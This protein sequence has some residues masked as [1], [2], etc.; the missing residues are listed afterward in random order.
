MLLPRAL[1]KLAVYSFLG[2]SMTGCMESSLLQTRHIKPTH[3]KNRISL[4]PLACA[5]AHNDYRHKTPLF[6]AL[7]N[8]FSSI[9][10]DVFLVDGELLVGHTL[11]GTSPD[12]TLEDLYLKPLKNLVDENN[13]SVYPGTAQNLLLMIDVKSDGKETY[14]ALHETLEKY[15]TM[16]TSF[17]ENDMRHGAVT[18]VISGHRPP[19]SI[20][21]KQPVRYAAYDGRLPDLLHKFKNSFMPM[22]S[23]NWNK[24]FKWRGNGP[25][26][27]KERDK[28]CKLV[29]QAHEN[30]QNI[31]FWDTPEKDPRA[32]NAVWATLLEAD[33][34]YINT[35][36][37]PELR[38]WLLE[39]EHRPF[40]RTSAKA[41][42]VVNE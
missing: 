17:Q 21:D 4:N 20:M 11:A 34:D 38:E 41:S 27:E 15:K 36:H 39:N 6:D 42:L 19:K 25:M 18:V 7:E 3:S 28:L 16:L 22:V 26:P 35:D 24:N 23:A 8:G 10:A 13:G 14:H 31:R 40:A 32:R 30:G 9:E 33:V 2:L 37:L 29:Q 12:R 1:K 5:H